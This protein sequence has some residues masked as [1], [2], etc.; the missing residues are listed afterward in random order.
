MWPLLSLTP[1]I[2]TTGPTLCHPRAP[3]TSRSSNTPSGSLRFTTDSLKSPLWVHRLSITGSRRHS[4]SSAKS[5]LVCSSIRNVNGFGRLQLPLSTSRPVW[6]Q[7]T[8]VNQNLSLDYIE[9]YLSRYRATFL[10]T[11]IPRELRRSG[12]PPSC[13]GPTRHIWAFSTGDSRP[14]YCP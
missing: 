1:S 14:S 7:S 3:A 13:I 12:S 8:P 2:T 9:L 4:L 11:Q 6:Y 10:Q 5:G